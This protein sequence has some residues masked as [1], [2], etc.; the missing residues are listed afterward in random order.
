MNPQP[1]KNVIVE[2]IEYEPPK[3]FSVGGLKAVISLI[4]PKGVYEK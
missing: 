4:I 2:R 3:R 1:V